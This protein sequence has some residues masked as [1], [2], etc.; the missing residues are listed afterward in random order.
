MNR[1]MFPVK[2]K[3]TGLVFD[4]IFCGIYLETG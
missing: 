4:S 2:S 1:R 3:V